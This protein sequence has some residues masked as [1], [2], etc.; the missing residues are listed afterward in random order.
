MAPREVTTAMSL[1]TWFAIDKRQRWYMN[2]LGLEMEEWTLDRVEACT[3]M[4]ELLDV[5]E[6]CDRMDRHDRRMERHAARW[7]A[8]GPSTALN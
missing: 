4:R 3:N 5:I 1:N 7:L 8:L 2:V 6:L